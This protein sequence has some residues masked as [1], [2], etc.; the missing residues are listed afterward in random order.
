MTANEFLIFDLIPKQ[1]ISRE[2]AQKLERFENLIDFGKIETKLRY[3]KIFKKYRK[4]Y[5]W[6]DGLAGH[7]FFV[8]WLGLG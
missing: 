5:E 8:I 7:N 6:L 3:F 1:T 2:N 4:E